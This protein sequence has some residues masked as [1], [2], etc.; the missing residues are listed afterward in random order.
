MPGCD[1]LKQLSRS[2]R[3]LPEFAARMG[4]EVQR[5]FAPQ[6]DFHGLTRVA[7]EHHRQVWFCVRAQQFFQRHRRLRVGDAKSTAV[8]PRHPLF[9]KRQQHARERHQ[10]HDQSNRYARAQ[11]QPEQD[12]SHLQVLATIAHSAILSPCNRSRET[13]SAG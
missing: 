11:V 7:A 1:L 12:F 2:R 5:A 6:V 4:I 3:I 13:T 9:F 10:Y 8:E